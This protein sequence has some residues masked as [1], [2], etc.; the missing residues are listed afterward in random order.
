MTYFQGTIA[1]VGATDNKNRFG[2]TVFKRLFKL[3]PDELIIGV[4]PKTPLIDGEQTVASLDDIPKHIDTVVMVVNPLLGISI[5]KQ[6]LQ[7]GVKKF[8]FQ[9]GAQSD[10]IAHVL[11]A[12]KA[13][14]SFGTCIL[15]SN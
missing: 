9:P 14:Y 1:V 12:A 3:F 8:W 6:A 11:T 7:L 10:E 2:Y 5:V 4:N 15:H 13:E